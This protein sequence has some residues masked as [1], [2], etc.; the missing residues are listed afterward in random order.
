MGGSGP[1]KEYEEARQ[2][3]AEAVTRH[4][5]RIELTSQQFL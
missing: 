2:E 3:K 1:N 5:D 4:H